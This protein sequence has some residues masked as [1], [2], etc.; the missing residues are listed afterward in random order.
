MLIPS[1]GRLSSA[2]DGR[3]QEVKDKYALKLPVGSNP[4]YDPITR[5]AAEAAKT[6]Q[7]CRCRYPV[8]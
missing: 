3:S 2:G 4:G 5:S 7:R 1:D 6:A 8:G